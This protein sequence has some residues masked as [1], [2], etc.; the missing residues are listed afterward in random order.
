MVVG[1]IS[2]VFYTVVNLP[3]TAMTPELTQD[4]DERTTL[5]GFRFSFSISGSILSLI[6]ASVIFKLIANRQQQYVVL[7]AICEVISVLSLYWCVW[8]TRDRIMAFE[9]KRTQRS[10]GGSSGCFELAQ[11]E[12]PP[13]TPI[14]E[15]LKQV[16]SK[17]K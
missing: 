3:Y 8:G 4:Y 13:P 14:G 2:Q 16:Y 5:N 15:Q 12:E 17:T 9:A 7:A 6:L 10:A 1:L 11:T